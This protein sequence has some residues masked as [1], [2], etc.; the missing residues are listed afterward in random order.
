MK[1][2]NR[3][4][5]VHRLLR[6]VTQSFFL[7]LQ[8]SLYENHTRPNDIGSHIKTVYLETH[9]RPL[10]AACAVFSLWQST[11]RNQ[12]SLILVTITFQFL[13]CFVFVFCFFTKYVVNKT[14]LEHLKIPMTR[15]SSSKEAAVGPWYWIYLD[16][17]ATIPPSTSKGYRCTQI[18][19]SKLSK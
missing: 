3:K 17:D 19:W 13:F 4:K 15:R 12:S 6:Y 8:N 11:S 18:I 16:A 10:R 2:S 1:T 5:C 14:N 9:F 7:Y